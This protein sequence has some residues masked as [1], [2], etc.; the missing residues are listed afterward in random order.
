[1]R[2]ISINNFK[3]QSNVNDAPLH[4]T[5]LNEKKQFTKDKKETHKSITDIEQEIDNL[6]LRK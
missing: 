1:M 4:Y 6:I 3:N 5:D 2:I